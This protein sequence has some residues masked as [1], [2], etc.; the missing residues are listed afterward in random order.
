MKFTPKIFYKMQIPVPGQAEQGAAP[1]S[2]L[3][4]VGQ[5]YSLFNPEPFLH[6]ADPFPN[7]L[8]IGHVCHQPK[9]RIARQQDFP[10]ADYPLL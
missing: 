10:M 7:L 5:F 6:P 9:A 8:Q 2:A 1:D 3:L 4:P